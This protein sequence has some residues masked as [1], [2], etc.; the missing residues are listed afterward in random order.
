MSHL[1]VSD[2]RNHKP[3]RHLPPQGRD[4]LQFLGRRLLLVWQDGRASE[5]SGREHFLVG[6]TH[7]PAFLRRDMP[8]CEP[9]QRREGRSVP[10]IQLAVPQ[11]R[12]WH[13]TAGTVT[14]HPPKIRAVCRKPLRNRL[15][16]FGIMPAGCRRAVFDVALDVSLRQTRQ[17]QAGPV[18][19]RAIAPARVEGIQVLVDCLAPAKG[20][21]DRVCAPLEP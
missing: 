7:L 20:K 11:E 8:C 17:Q 3:S 21:L 1:P 9:G 4:T 12:L 15:I 19:Q 6:G 16:G 5:D 10:F 13:G 14:I 18:R 2:R